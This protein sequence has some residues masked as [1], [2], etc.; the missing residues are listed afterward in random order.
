MKVRSSILALGAFF[1]IA[2][3]ISACGSGVPG[4]AVVDVA[5]NPISTQAVNHW[6]YVAAKS[7][8]EQQSPT[9]PVIVPNDPPQFNKCIALAKKEF[10]SLA[11]TADKTVRG[12]CQQAFTSLKNSVLDFLI[13][14]YWYQADAA[15]LG[16][17]VTNAQ[18]QKAFATAQGR[19]PRSPRRQ[20]STP[21]SARPARRSPDLLYRFRVNAILQK[22][23]RPAHQARHPRRRSR[24]T[25]TAICRSSGRRRRAT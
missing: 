4:N 17:K 15:K 16:I 19:S 12:E 1:V 7:Q 24:R 14:A 21:S 6:M 11:K 18:V 10:P 5:G 23:A 22:L 13:T 25:T 2:V 8:A 9:S 20:G 3:G